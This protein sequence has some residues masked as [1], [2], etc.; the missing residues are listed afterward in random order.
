MASTIWRCL[1]AVGLCFVLLAGTA[2]AQSSDAGAAGKDPVAV[3]EIRVGVRAHRGD[4]K[5]AA[6][7][8]LVQG[9]DVFEMMAD[10]TA[11]D[12]HLARREAVEHVS[13]V[14]IGAVGE[15]EGAKG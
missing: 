12:L 8:A 9:L 13:V 3:G 10:L 4:L 5:F 15:R 6:E 2:R 7:R 11:R 14:G 1:R